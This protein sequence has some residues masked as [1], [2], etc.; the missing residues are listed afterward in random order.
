MITLSLITT[1]RFG[2]QNSLIT[3]KTFY[4]ALKTKT[5]AIC[6]GWYWWLMDF[7]YLINSG[8]TRPKL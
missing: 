1:L 5:P 8:L 6:W 4:A 3:L 7:L 2:K